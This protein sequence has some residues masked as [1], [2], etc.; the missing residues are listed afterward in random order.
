MKGWVFAFSLTLLVFTLCLLLYLL[1]GINQYWINHQYCTN[2]RVLLMVNTEYILSYSSLTT[3]LTL[4]L[5]WKVSDT[6]LAL[7]AKPLVTLSKHS[8]LSW[9]P[10]PHLSTNPLTPNLPRTA[11]RYSYGPFLLSISSGGNSAMSQE[12]MAH[13]TLVQKEFQHSIQEK[14]Y[15]R[16]VFPLSS[17]DMDKKDK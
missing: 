13:T 9:L 8:F 7:E 16:S 2:K 17:V 15:Y 1:V 3:A 11:P 12:R 4:L 5:W 10:L 6:N 14:F